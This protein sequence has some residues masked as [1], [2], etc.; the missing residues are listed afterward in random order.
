M[1]TLWRTLKTIE[2]F[3]SKDFEIIFELKVDDYTVSPR[4]KRIVN[5]ELRQ[6]NNSNQSYKWSFS[7]RFNSIDEARSFIDE[8]LENNFILCP[9]EE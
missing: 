7:N 9:F 6:K 1:K 2:L 3:Q 5:Y 4:D 8:F